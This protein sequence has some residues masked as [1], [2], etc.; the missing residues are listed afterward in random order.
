MIKNIN[1]EHRSIQSLSSLDHLSHF[2]LTKIEK[3]ATISLSVISLFAIS[4]LGI[5][6]IYEPRQYPEVPTSN[7]SHV[8]H[9]A[10][11]QGAFAWIRGDAEDSG[12]ESWD[13]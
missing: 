3:D 9:P 5:R 2:P 13:G 10:Y 12:D 1:L 7:G 8:L 4:E 11:T 6:E